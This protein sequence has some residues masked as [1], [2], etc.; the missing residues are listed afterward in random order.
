[1]ENDKR[2]RP[3]QE[4][5]EEQRPKTRWGK[6]WEWTEFG[7]KSG[8]E[9]MQLLIIPVMIAIGGLLFNWAQDARQRE[10]AQTRAE[11]QS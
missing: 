1:M 3:S 5:E 11:A 2:L 7:E 6:L 10:D 4:L 8:W 9:W